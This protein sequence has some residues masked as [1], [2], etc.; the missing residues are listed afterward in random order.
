[1]FTNHNRTTDTRRGSNV[2]LTAA[3]TASSRSRW[4]T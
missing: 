3:V 4:R 1:M 2:G